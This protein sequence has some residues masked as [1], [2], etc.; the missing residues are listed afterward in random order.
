MRQYLMNGHF[1]ASGRVVRGRGRDG[2]A[3]S[4]VMVAAA[5]MIVFAVG[6]KEA[7]T[8]PDGA[9]SQ[10]SE[11]PAPVVLDLSTSKPANESEAGS[12][13]ETKSAESKPSA[14]GKTATSQPEK[15]AAP[16]PK[17]KSTFV[18]KSPYPVMLFVNSPD[19]EQPGWVKI[20]KLAEENQLAKLYGRFPMQNRIYVDTTNV[21]RIRIHIDQLPLD[22]NERLVLQIDKQ[23][24]VIS[25]RKDPTVT[26]ERLATGEWTVSK[27]TKK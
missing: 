23:G 25:S 10:P 15:T 21:R 26:L 8:R 5:A 11:L 17:P 22:P 16:Q 3:A 9:Q 7:T 2:I 24:M 19:E 14:D 1:I 12:E 18:D 27:P 13:A 6:C 20:E 4:I